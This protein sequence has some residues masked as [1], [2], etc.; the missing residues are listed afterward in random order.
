MKYITAILI[1]MGLCVNIS[2]QT[3]TLTTSAP[4]AWQKLSEITIPFENNMGGADIPVFEKEKY[5]SIH[6]KIKNGQMEL[7]TVVITFENG[8][9]QEVLLNERLDASKDS[10][11]IDLL[12]DRRVITSVSFTVAAIPRTDDKN[13]AIQLYASTST[14]EPNGKV[15]TKSN[16]TKKKMK[17]VANRYKK[18]Q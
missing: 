9:K 10:R 12:G 4:L 8:E 5:G 18:I 11:I 3:N 14:V 1:L 15:I 16:S 6:F 17:P 7:K 13:V 2:A